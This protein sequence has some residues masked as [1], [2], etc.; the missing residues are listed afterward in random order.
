MH[1][2]TL[3]HER[4]SP[5]N[6]VFIHRNGT[7]KIAPYKK[8]THISVGARIAR[9]KTK[10]NH[11]TNGKPEN[12]CIPPSHIRTTEHASAVAPTGCAFTVCKA[13]DVQATPIFA[14]NFGTGQRLSNSI[15]QKT[16]PKSL[17]GVGAYLHSKSRVLALVPSITFCKSSPRKKRVLISYARVGVLFACRR[18][19]RR[20]NRFRIPPRRRPRWQAHH[21]PKVAVP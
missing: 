4:I 8:S 20:R 7:V 12:K 13:V 21:L 18:R 17:R 5:Y 3:D 10:A 1:C 11:R 15:T 16:D 6:A 9:P 19:G 2:S 14:Q